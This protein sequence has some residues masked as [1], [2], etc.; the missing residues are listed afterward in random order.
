MKERGLPPSRHNGVFS[1]SKTRVFSR[2]HQQQVVAFC[3]GGGVVVS[4]GGGF[5]WFY[6]NAVFGAFGAFGAL[7][8]VVVVVVVVAGQFHFVE[9]SS[10]E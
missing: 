3:A 7:A 1:Q 2:K 4:G 8:A 6:V 9:Q 5:L 10:T